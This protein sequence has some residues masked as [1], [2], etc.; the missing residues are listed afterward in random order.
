MGILDAVVAAWAALLGM[1]G[2]LDDATHRWRVRRAALAVRRE[3][4]LRVARERAVAE[5]DAE[6]RRAALLENK[7]R[8]RAAVKIQWWWRRRLYEPGYGIVYRRAAESFR[9]TATTTTQRAVFF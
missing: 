6:E 5:L 8:W 1:A 2:R 4:E 3:R 9:A 7:A